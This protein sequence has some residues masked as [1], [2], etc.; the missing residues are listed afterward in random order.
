MSYTQIMDK[1]VRFFDIRTDTRTMVQVYYTPDLGPRP[2]PYPENEEARI[3]WALRRCESMARAHQAVPDDQI[4]FLSPYTGTEIF[5]EAFGCPVHYSGDN[6]PFALP[7]IH[8]ASQV[9]SLRTPSAFA[10]PLERPFRIARRLRDA[11]PDA[12]VQ[13][14]DI[15][16]P[17]DIAAL[18][19][20]KG[21]FYAACIDEPEAVEELCHRV[22]SVLTRFLDAWFQ[23]FGT[24]YVAHYPDFFVRGGATLSEDEA[25]SISPAMFR[26][27][28]MPALARLSERY[29]GLCVHCCANSERQWDNFKAIPG[30]RLLNL[31]Q[32]E[33]VL[34]RAYSVFSQAVPQMHAWCGSGFPGPDWARHIP[35]QAHVVL[36][37]GADSED[38]AKR[39]LD[40]LLSVRS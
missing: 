6:M 24:D 4:P 33:P 12:P 40:A 19:W 30:L 8:S 32:P 35:P 20:E 16:S 36:Y 37:A 26:R 7:R 1:W 2:L 3:T 13:L 21:D 25:G 9:R 29:G 5:A 10:P 23:E 15:Q 17:F 38:Q 11:F 34:T 22:E 18:I 28:C 31:N 27:F 39:T 14:P